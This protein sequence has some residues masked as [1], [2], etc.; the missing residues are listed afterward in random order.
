M[1]NLE[2]I[3][4]SEMRLLTLPHPY[5]LQASAQMHYT[6]DVLRQ[7]CSLSVCL[8][9]LSHVKLHWK[10]PDMLLKHLCGQMTTL[11][12]YT[13]V[14]KIHFLLPQ[15]STIEGLVSV[16][17]VA[18]FFMSLWR[19]IHHRSPPS[20]SC[21]T[22]TTCGCRRGWFQS[23]CS[24]SKTIHCYFEIDELIFLQGPKPV[25]VFKEALTFL[26]CSFKI[27]I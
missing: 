7:C 22:T 19:I 4:S 6:S 25:P 15:L 17:C 14:L 18:V 12:L 27:S 9:W 8:M 26:E 11:A 16:L 10:H 20:S 5:F 1:T 2:H 23:P 13:R 21:F 24:L 3:R